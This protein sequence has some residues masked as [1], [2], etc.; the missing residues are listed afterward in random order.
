MY[1]CH[2][3]AMPRPAAQKRTVSLSSIVPS[4]FHKSANAIDIF[5]S[6]FTGNSLY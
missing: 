5:Y 6:G 3:M 4:R 1:V 2:C